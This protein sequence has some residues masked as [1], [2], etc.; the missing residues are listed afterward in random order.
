MGGLFLFCG[1]KN[2][3][4]DQT[5]LLT[6]ILG[7]FGIFGRCVKTGTLM[8]VGIFMEFSVCS[9]AIWPFLVGV[10]LPKSSI[11]Q[12]PVDSTL[13]LLSKI[14]SIESL[15]AREILTKPAD[16]ALLKENIRAKFQVVPKIHNLAGVLYPPW[17]KC[18]KL[19]KKMADSPHNDLTG[20]A[21]CSMMMRLPG[22]SRNL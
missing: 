19:F 17:P 16:G 1:C 8:D 20:V 14:S 13:L 10:E 18:S 9:P 15:M 7:S 5:R 11:Y 4:D 22:M 21:R 2:P 12:Y 6:S 3:N